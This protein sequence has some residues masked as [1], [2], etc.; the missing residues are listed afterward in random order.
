MIY[1][2]TLHPALDRALRVQKIKPDDSNR[3][4]RRVGIRGFPDVI[5]PNVHELSR[6]VGGD[7]KGIGQVMKAAQD[8]REQGV[9]IVLVSM[10]ARGILLVAEK[11]QYLAS[12]PNVKVENTIGAG[13]SAVAGVVYE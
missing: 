2:I 10:G 7:L 1:T 11:E 3:V 13:D 4:E 8:V 5:K 6:L 9:E 12:P